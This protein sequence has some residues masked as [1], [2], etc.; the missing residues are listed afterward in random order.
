MYITCIWLILD[1]RHLDYF[2]D[3]HLCVLRMVQYIIVCISIRSI[4]GT[5]TCMLASAR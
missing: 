2:I 5:Q 3:L 1:V 4:Q